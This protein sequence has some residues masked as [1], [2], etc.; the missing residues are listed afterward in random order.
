VIIT[1]AIC[2]LNRAESLGRTLQSLAEMRVPDGLVWEVVVVNNDCTDDTDAVIESFADGRL[3][4]RREFQQQRGLSLARNRAVD[5]AK[6]D[7]IAWIDDDVIVEPGWLGAYADAFLRWPEAA[8]FGGPITPRFVPPLPKWFAEAEPY[9]SGRV[10]A[11]RDV[12][13]EA[14]ILLAER[15][16]P[17]GPNFALRAIEQRAFLYD[18]ELGPGPG[19]RRRAEETDVILR[20]LGSGATGRWVPG[21]QVEHWSQ[22]NQETLEYVKDWFK[23]LGEAE[24]VIEA[25]QATVGPLWFGAP[26][27][28]WRRLITGWAGYLFY[29]VFS[30]PRAWVPY[31]AIR[32]TASGAIQQ[33]RSLGGH[34]RID[35]KS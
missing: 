1:V 27:W 19:R 16:I 10:F 24:A 35:P 3:P 6:G 17:Y 32:I 11:R 8:V 7:Y 28:L 5:T 15:R 13:E 29:R 33:W 26:R 14:E 30:T 22:P 12:D 9:L 34:A 18:L 20:V 23:T 25:R 31:M 2:T 4:I 21:A